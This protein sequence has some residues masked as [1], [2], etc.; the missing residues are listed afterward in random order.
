MSDC[1][2]EA[3]DTLHDAG[4]TI[5]PPSW[6]EEGMGES[7]S[8]GKRVEPAVHKCEGYFPEPWERFVSFVCT[9]IGSE[10]L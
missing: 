9:E 4:G 2:G 1:R 10:G 5:Q 8:G 7:C 6:D 3:A